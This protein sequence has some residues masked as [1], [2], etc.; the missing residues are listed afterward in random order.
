MG[1]SIGEYLGTAFAAVS[2]E[3]KAVGAAWFGAMAP[4]GVGTTGLLTFH[5]AKSRPTAVAQQALD[6]LEQAGLIVRERV[7]L[8]PAVSYRPLV[9]F[10]PVLA[11]MLATNDRPNVKLVEPIAAGGKTPC[12]I[13]VEHTDINRRQTGGAHG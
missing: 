11:W 4:G 12:E 1:D 9:S 7:Y 2:A 6:E 8:A 10:A 5:M 3:A 13:E